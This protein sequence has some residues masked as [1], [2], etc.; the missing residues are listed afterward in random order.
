MTRGI[1]RFMFQNKN[2]NLLNISI[3][4]N[5]VGFQFN[6]KTNAPKID[7]LKKCVNKKN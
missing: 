5:L 7:Y 4:D 2:I 1:M 3:D 6:S